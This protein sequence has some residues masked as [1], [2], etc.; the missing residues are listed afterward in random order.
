MT[1]KAELLSIPAFLS[2]SQEI[3]LKPGEIFMRGGD[4]AEFMVVILEGALQGRGEINGETIAISL[5]GG[6]VSTLRFSS[7]SATVCGEVS[8]SCTAG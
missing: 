4:P 6:D 2:Q 8:T 7:S 5:K 1:D 3:P